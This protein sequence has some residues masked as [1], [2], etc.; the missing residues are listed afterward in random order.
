M[1]VKIEVQDQEVRKAL[2]GLIALGKN[3]TPAMREIAGA[4]GLNPFFI[5]AW[6]QT[7]ECAAGHQSTIPLRGSG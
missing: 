4:L 5:R 3:L 2:N 1:Q 7:D 6:I